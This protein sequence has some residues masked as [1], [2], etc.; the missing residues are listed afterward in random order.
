MTIVKVIHILEKWEDTEKGKG[1]KITQ[2][3]HKKLVTEVASREGK[4]TR[5]ETFCKKL[6]HNTQISSHITSVQLNFHKLNTSE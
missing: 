1:S 2:E 6:K 4:G 5:G 3:G